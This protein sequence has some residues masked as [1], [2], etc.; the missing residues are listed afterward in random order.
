MSKNKPMYAVYEEY[1]RNNKLYQNKRRELLREPEER[2]HEI[3][4]GLNI[5]NLSRDL[6]E[7]IKILT[8]DANELYK[9]IYH[10]KPTKND[11]SKFL[12]ITEELLYYYDLIPEEQRRKWEALRTLVGSFADLDGEVKPKELEDNELFKG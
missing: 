12:R 11:V 9:V 6:Q 7:R 10:I 4:T 5:Y 3:A 1:L 2:L 8:L